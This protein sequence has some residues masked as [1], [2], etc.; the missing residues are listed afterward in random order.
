MCKSRETTAAWALYV[1]DNRTNVASCVNFTIVKWK[2]RR[3]TTE[4]NLK[5]QTASGLN[6]GFYRKQVGFVGLL[7]FSIPFG[8]VKSAT[9]NPRLRNTARDESSRSAD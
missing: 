1:M 5:G 9:R 6:S 7:F 4:L 3:S 2:E 8:F